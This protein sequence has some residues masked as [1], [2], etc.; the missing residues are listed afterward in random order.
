MR[1]R[2]RNFN[3]NRP[4]LSTTIFRVEKPGGATLRNAGR[5]AAPLRRA[6]EAEEIDPLPNRFNEGLEIL[7]VVIEIKTRPGR[8][9]DAETAHQQLSAVVAGPDGDP[10]PVERRGQIMRVDPFAVERD[11]RSPVLLLRRSVYRCHL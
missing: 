2:P 10:L 7:S 11:Q 6:K 1:V 3:H 9:G 5:A 4:I 8:P